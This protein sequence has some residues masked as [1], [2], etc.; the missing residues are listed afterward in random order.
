VKRMLRELAL[1]SRLTAAYIANPVATNLVSFQQRDSTHWASASWRDSNEGYAGGRFAM[2]INAIWTPHALESMNTILETIPT[3]GISLDSL[4]RALPELAAATALGGYV[5]NPGSLR[6]AIDVWKRAS[7][8]FVVSLSPAEVQSHVLARLAALPENE[9]RHWTN[10][11]AASKAD[12][13][14]L[15]FL[16][17][18]LDA[19]GRPI[20]VAN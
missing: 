15:S 17:L 7:R 5:R 11:L 18:S 14:S 13:D 10:V 8:H 16:V 20:G 4:A 12:Q 19:S 1:V 6:H 9:R 3:L 2:D